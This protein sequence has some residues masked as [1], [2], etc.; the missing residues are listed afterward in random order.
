M[1]NKGYFGLSSRRDLLVGSEVP[2]GEGAP[3]PEQLTSLKRDFTGCG[4]TPSLVFGIRAKSQLPYP[5]SKNKQRRNTGFKRLPR[6]STCTLDLRG[7]AAFASLRRTE[8]VVGTV[9]LVVL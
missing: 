7:L 8:I 1:T 5:P 6:A 3:N 4:P 9:T 2:F